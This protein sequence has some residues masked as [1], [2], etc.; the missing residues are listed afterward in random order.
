MEA[1]DF[2]V[3]PLIMRSS[4]MGLI[5]DLA[6]DVVDSCKA[7][8]DSDIPSCRIESRSLQGFELFTNLYVSEGSNDQI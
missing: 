2:V 7:L 8:D 3:C 5:A 4:L 1:S 6:G